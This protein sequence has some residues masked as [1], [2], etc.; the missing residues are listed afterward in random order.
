MN[1]GFPPIPIPASQHW[2]NARLRVVPVVVFGAALVAIAF[3]WD[4]HVAAPTLVGQ[5]EAQLAAVS[6]IKPGTLVGLTVSRFQAVKAGDIIGRGVT[7]DPQVLEAS[8]AVIHSEIELLRVTMGPVVT[9][10]RNAINFAQVRLDWMKERAGLAAARVNLQ[11]TE[12]E[13]HRSE[14]LFKAKL[15]SEASRD[16]AQAAYQVSVHEVEEL[17][18]LLTEGEKS[19]KDLQGTNNSDISIVSDAPLQAAIAVQESKLRQVEAELNPVT[20]KAPIDGVVALIEHFSGEAVIAGQ[21]IVS[22]AAAEPTRIVGYVRSP[23]SVEPAAGDR[24][25]IR[26]RRR[27]RVTASAQITAIGAQLETLPAVFSAAGRLDPAQQGLPVN[28]SLPGNLKIHPG[29]LVDITLLP[30]AN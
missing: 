28:I 17:S 15:V 16:T 10:Q 9:Q 26:T 12:S 3:L 29:E 7:T 4:A 24:V 19:F 21:P 5:A 6:S 1:N 18:A 27:H 23:L 13:W 20:L 2:L 22:I 8:L 14:E 11:L 25:E 30:Q